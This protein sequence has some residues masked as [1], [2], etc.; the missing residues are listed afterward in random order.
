[1]TLEQQVVSCSLQHFSFSY[2]CKFFI[3]TSKILMRVN[4]LLFEGFQPEDVAIL[5]LF[6]M[7]HFYGLT[8]RIVLDVDNSLNVNNSA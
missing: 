3:G 4:V 1:M 5:F 6:S 8:A 7:K 2:V